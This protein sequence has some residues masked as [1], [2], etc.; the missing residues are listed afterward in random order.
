MSLLKYLLIYSFYIMS[1]TIYFN[2]YQFR[3]Y[4]VKVEDLRK[5]YE[6]QLFKKDL[7]KSEMFRI[8][9]DLMHESLEDLNGK[10]KE[11]K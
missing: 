2:P 4:A 9:I 3:E 8:I 6:K 5:H 1:M 7:S 11:D 10:V